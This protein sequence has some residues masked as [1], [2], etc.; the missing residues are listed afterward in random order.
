ML[1]RLLIAIIGSA[2][3]FVWAL[4]AIDAGSI[5]QQIQLDQSQQHLP[6]ETEPT[7]APVEA[8][9]AGSEQDKELHFT[10]RKINLQNV[11]AFEEGKLLDLLA[12]T[13]GQEISMDVLRKRIKRITDYYHAHDYPAAYAF[14]PEQTIGEDGAIEVRVLEGYLGQL[15]VHNHSRVI[16]RA[17]ELRLPELKS[18]EILQQGQLERSILLINDI[19]G[20]EAQLVFNPGKDPGFTD[21]DIT[22]EE[23]PRFNAMLAADNQGS[24]YTGDTNRVT[25]RPEVNNLIGLGDKLSGSIMSGGAGLGYT[26]AQY[27]LPTAL[28]GPWRVGVEYSEVKYSLGKEF[29]AAH[30]EGL[31]RTA[32]SYVGYPLIRSAM[33]NMNVEA[34]YQE[35]MI[36]DIVNAVSDINERKSYSGILVFNGDWRDSAH[37]M[38][39]YSIT[40]G[41]L[42]FT[43]WL[44]WFID[45]LTAQTFGRYRKTNWSYTRM[46]PVSFLNNTSLNLTVNGQTTNRNLDS[47]EKMVLG[48]AHAVRAYPASEGM[49]DQGEILTLELKHE[50]A[51][52]YQVSTFY[53]Y[54]HGSANHNPWPAVVHN[55]RTNLGGVGVGFQYNNGDN[56]SFSINCAWRTRKNIPLSGPDTP[57]G[58]VWMEIGI[59]L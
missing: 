38:W 20:I 42:D 7:I 10:V 11:T 33:L 46:Q 17:A 49:S 54:G 41:R 32:N 12:D 48:G 50:F 18:G 19:P 59:N 23:K 21:I 5:Q 40:A 34:K 25:L 22:M 28:T 53:D 45:G 8:P 14:L 9:I 37:N 31:T 30:A 2:P 1:N 44:H 39:N 35:K 13:I 27:Q 4:P 15:R 26:Q 43:Y 6:V 29:A 47:S 52:H 36:R 16:T 55:N 58:R 3:G 24:R 51:P 57:G 56:V